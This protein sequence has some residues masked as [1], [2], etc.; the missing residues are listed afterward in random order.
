MYIVVIA[1]VYVVLMMAVAEALSSQGTLLGAIITFLFYG[2]LPLSIVV[3][4]MGSP[5][6]RRRRLAAEQAAAAASAPAA[7][8]PD[9]RGEAPGAPIAA[10]RKEG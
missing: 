6:R 7:I 4:V 10:E 9:G 5:A 3:Y 2:V 1:W 8:D